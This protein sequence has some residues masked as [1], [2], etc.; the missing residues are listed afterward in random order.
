MAWGVEL[1]GATP[2]TLLAPAISRN[3][4]PWMAVVSYALDYHKMKPHRQ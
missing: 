2:E 4:R 1:I 3:R